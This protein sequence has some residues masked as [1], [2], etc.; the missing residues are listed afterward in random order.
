MIRSK[1]KLITH[2]KL[3]FQNEAYIPRLF[4]MNS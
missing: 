3:Y 4:D 1:N 2:A